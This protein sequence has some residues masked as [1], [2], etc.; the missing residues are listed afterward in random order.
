LDATKPLK[1]AEK[2]ERIAPP[3]WAMEKVKAL[4]ESL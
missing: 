3:A 1:E 4:L 2:Y